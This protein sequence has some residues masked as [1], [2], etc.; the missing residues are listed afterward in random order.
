MFQGLKDRLDFRRELL[1]WQILYF[2]VKKLLD[3][4]EGEEWECE[5][6]FLEGWWMN[7]Q[8]TLKKLYKQK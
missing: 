5:K 3:A 7:M 8:E 2:R 6:E 4:K 1:E